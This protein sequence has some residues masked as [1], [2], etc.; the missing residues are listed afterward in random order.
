MPNHFVSAVCEGE[1]CR[2]GKPATHKVAE[3]ILDW[4][5]PERRHELTSYVC[6]EHFAWLM[7]STAPCYKR[8]EN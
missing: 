2:C 6:C 7:G 8:E 5:D 3:V 4:G 1:I